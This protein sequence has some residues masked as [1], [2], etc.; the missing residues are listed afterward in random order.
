MIY[1]VRCNK[2]R[3]VK[4]PPEVTSEKGESL[5]CPSCC[6]CKNTLCA[7]VN[8]FTVVSVR[9]VDDQKAASMQVAQYG[10]GE[11]SAGGQ[12]AV[13]N[14]TNLVQ[15]RESSLRE[16]NEYDVSV[17]DGYD[18][19]DV[20]SRDDYGSPRISES[21]VFEVNPDIDR[22]VI[23]GMPTKIYTEENRVINGVKTYPLK[24]ALNDIFRY[25]DTGLVFKNKFELTENF[26]WLL[27]KTVVNADKR[28]VDKILENENYSLSQK[29]FYLFYDVVFKYNPP[30]GFFWCDEAFS[31]SPLSPL[32]T[33]KHNFMERYCN[34]SPSGEQFRKIYAERRNEIVHYLHCPGEEKLFDDL[35][36]TLARDNREIVLLGFKNG[37]TPLKLGTLN[38]FIADMRTP[39][40]LLK[41]SNMCAF[42]VKYRVTR[43][44]VFKR[45]GLYD[46][47]DAPVINEFSE[48]NCVYSALG[49]QG[50]SSYNSEYD[51]FC[52]LLKEY[53]KVFKPTEIKISGMRFTTADF[54]VETEN[55]V[56]NFCQ[57]H[58]GSAEEETYERYTGQGFLLKSLCDRGVL[59][60][61]VKGCENEKLGALLAL[62]EKPDV[63]VYL[64]KVSNP[65]FLFGN[66]QITAAEYIDGILDGDLPTVCGQLR[67]DVIAEAFFATRL[68]GYSGDN[69]SKMMKQCQNL[70][71]TFCG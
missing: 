15:S 7:S 43:T 69:L 53:I 5:P 25:W 1:I 63:K 70:F 6:D 17:D 48:E 23:R 13:S 26:I 16:D 3:S 24:N 45:E 42:L 2:G 61:F 55:A 8:K 11:M 40:N 36:E 65:V 54:Y 51:C 71:D 12:G 64:Q 19:S 59:E 32:F 41:M 66:R 14:S 67:G 20:P 28:E 4:L 22:F 10:E 29:F 62:I 37:Y 68:K 30:R 31:L 49:L 35:T 47:F 38:E 50:S 58:F 57:T 9:V 34:A 33:D 21:A 39:S 27:T 56:R 52:A 44:G 18:I 60:P 46:K